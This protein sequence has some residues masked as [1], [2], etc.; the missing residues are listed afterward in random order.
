VVLLLNAVRQL[1]SAKPVSGQLS[2][3]KHGKPF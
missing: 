3:D 2:R 1:I